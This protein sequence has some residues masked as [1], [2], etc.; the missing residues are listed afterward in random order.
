M[1]AAL[2]ELTELLSRFRISHNTYSRSGQK[3]FAQSFPIEFDPR[4]AN[5]IDLIKKAIAN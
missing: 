1:F 5:M 2:H 4:W 3:P